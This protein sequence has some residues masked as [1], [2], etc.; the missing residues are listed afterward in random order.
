[1]RSEAGGAAV[2]IYADPLTAEELCAALEELSLNV[3]QIATITGK[4]RQAVWRWRKGE[5]AVPQYVATIIELIRRLR[6]AERHQR[7]RE[8]SKHGYNRAAG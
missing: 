7:L 4:S 3:Q 2:L 6:A 1:M 8:T 5:V